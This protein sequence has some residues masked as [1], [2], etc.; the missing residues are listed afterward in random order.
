M[1]FDMEEKVKEKVQDITTSLYENTRVGSDT[2]EVSRSTEE[3]KSI[4]GNLHEYEHLRLGG[5]KEVEGNTRVTHATDENNEHLEK[6]GA[7]LDEG[8][9]EKLRKEDKLSE[10]SISQRK[11]Q[12]EDVQIKSE[13]ANTKQ[14]SRHALVDNS[15]DNTDNQG[16]HKVVTKHVNA[17]EKDV[18]RRIRI[19]V[20]IFSVLV[21]T[22]YL[23]V[24]LSMVLDFSPKGKDGGWSNWGS[25]EACSAS[26]SV[27]LRSR[28]RLCDNPEPSTDG[29]QCLG[30]SN[31]ADLCTKPTC[32]TS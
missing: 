23:F 3:N 12:T 27:G 24:F 6:V 16:V 15:N 25:W 1:E 5:K 31:Q 22:I 7:S 11:I 29:K 30:N 8:Q 14:P 19:V 28:S 4:K 2:V 10:H 18:F 17:L 32:P 26:C 20:I 13:I 21:L 9:Y